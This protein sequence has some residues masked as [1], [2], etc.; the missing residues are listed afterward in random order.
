MRPRTL[1]ITAFG[2]Y[3]DTLTLDFDDLGDHGLFLLHGPTGAG[4]TTL[5][6]AM[7]FALYGDAS[8]GEREMRELRSDLAAD[9]AV[10]RIEFE[11][12]LGPERYRIE[13]MPTQVRPGKKTPQQHSASIW[14]VGVGG[15]ALLATGVREVEACVHDLLGLKSEQF[16][17]V[18]VLPQGQFRALLTASSQDREDILCA[19]FDTAAFLQLENRLKEAAA[20]ATLE[21]AGYESELQGLLKAYGVDTLVA[22]ENRVAQQESALTGAGIAEGRAREKRAAML[23]ARDLAIGDEALFGAHD[24][25][26]QRHA[27]IAAS[28]E[29]RVQ[30]S[31]RLAAG[32][33]AQTVLAVDAQRQ[34]VLT[35]LNEIGTRYRAADDVWRA[36][37]ARLGAAIQALTAE[38]E[39]APEREAAT[40]RVQYLQG[41]SNDVQSYQQVIAALTGHDRDSAR[42]EASIGGF[43]TSLDAL[44]LVTLEQKLAHAEQAA[45]DLPQLEARVASM[46]QLSKWKQRLDDTGRKIQQAIEAEATAGKTALAADLARLTAKEHHVEVRRHFLAQQAG[47]LAGE[48]KAGEP[49]S[50]CGSPHHPAPAIRPPDAPTQADVDAAEGE[51]EAA[52]AAFREADVKR[53]GAI[54]VRTTLEAQRKELQD[55]LGTGVDRPLSA[56][57]A[58]LKSLED[59]VETCRRDANQV[60]ACRTELETAHHETKRLQLAVGEA[61]TQRATL[62]GLIQGLKVQQQ[63]LTARLP[64]DVRSTSALTELI[65]GAEQ[66]ARTLDGQLTRARKE[67]DDQRRAADETVGLLN[68][69]SGELKAQSAAAD[70]ATTEFEA[71][72]SDAGFED[73]DAY[74]AV[75]L[76]SD[77]LEALHRQINQDLAEVAQAQVAL[78]EALGKL[79]GRTRPDVQAAQQAFTD[80]DTEHSTAIGTSRSLSDALNSWK[81]GVSKVTE[82]EIKHA[83]RKMGAE[84]LVALA[85]AA[86]GTTG[87][88]ISFHRYVLGTFLDEVLELASHRLREMSRHRYELRRADDGK[89]GLELEVFDHYT[90]RARSAKSLSG[91]ESFQ[92]ALS[93]A[94]GLAEVVQQQAGGRHLETVFIDEGFGSLDPQ[95][96]DLAL[97]CL[98]D[99]QSNGRLVGVVSHV[100]ELQQHIQARLEVTSGHGG[101]TAQFV[102]A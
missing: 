90:S 30:R 14:R 63:A 97:D 76:T 96:L 86:K 22:L 37:D 61:E 29:V 99:L 55:N 19:L 9:T 92:A 21:T 24:R 25:A 46:Q 81:V 10:A 2:P 49:C 101:S 64:E 48:L 65:G 40:R 89:G 18:V 50:V 88:R 28:A 11:F 68:T 7:C 39:R 79:E 93:L 59:T 5:L 74:R 43:K 54:S 15:D 83:D 71:A 56:L 26:V 73:P 70:Q 75:M 6:D 44:N 52:D 98:I 38:E 8:G 41:L 84:R 17:Q 57:R 33:R 51:E 16:R 32:R 47:I 31:Q 102:V 1:Q 67:V 69:C 3:K 13:R 23:M 62:T 94:L 35:D 87:Q 80:A 58:D 20:R 85:K 36:A 4:K 72:L 78:K 42:I 66:A 45:R 53:T 34:R 77:Q 12:S 91:G 82:L 27:E 95:A 100:Q 60:T